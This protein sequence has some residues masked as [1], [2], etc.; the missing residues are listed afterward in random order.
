MRINNESKSKNAEF[1]SRYQKLNKEQKLAVDTTDGPVMVIA[2]PGSGKTELLSLRVANILKLGLATPSNILCLTF[3]ENGA[4]NMRERLSSLIKED[5]FRVNI[6]TFHAFCNYVIGRYPEYFYNATN[7]SQA[8]DI[9]RAEIITEIFKSLLHKHPLS[10]KHPELGFAYL[11]DVTDR[12]KHIKSGGYTPEEYKTIV[13]SIKEDYKDINEVFALWPVERLNVKKLEVFNNIISSLDKLKT[14]TS[15]FIS[16]ALKNAVEESFVIGKT[17]PIADFKKKYLAVDESTPILKESYNYDK[18]LAVAEIYELYENKMHELGLYDYDDTIIEVAHILRNK[19]VLRNELEEQ[20]QY[21]MIDEFQ[22]TNLAQM[23][24]VKAITSSPIHEGHPNVCVVGDDDQAI[25]KF[26]GAEV[27]HIME[28]RE[29]TYKDVQTIV[30]DKNYRSTKDV[31]SF[32]RQIITKGK[33]RLENRFEDIVKELKSENK[34]LPNGKIEIIKYN[35]K[36]E[37]YSDV[38]RKIKK[39]LDDG[40]DPKEIA[41]L[42]RNHKDLQAILPYLDKLS[43]PYEYIKKANVFDEEH[44]RQLIIVCEYVSSVLNYENNKD[45]LLPEILSYKFLNLSHKEIFNVAVNAK[46]K[47]ISWIEALKISEDEKLHK[48]YELLTDLSVEAK[49]LP[50]ENLIEKFIEKSNFK[51]FYFS[52]EKLKNTP[53]TYVYFLA[54]LKTFIDALREWKKGETITASDVTQFVKM[55]KDNNIP[56]ISES[57]FTRNKFSIQ[58]M[59]AHAAKGLEFE[60]VFII[61][62]HDKPWTRGNMVNKAPIPS[63]LSQLINPAGDEEDDFIRLFF[64]AITRAKHTLH[65]SGH[66]EMLRYLP[67][68]LIK[69][70]DAKSLEISEEDHESILGIGVNK[71]KE[72]E[73]AMLSKLVENY[74]MP[75][76]HLNNFLDIKNG[77]PIFFVEQNLLHFPQPMNASGAYGSAIHKAIEEMIVYPKYNAGEKPKLSH[78]LS[79]FDFI[80]SRSRLNISDY[81]FMKDRGEIVLKKYYDEKIKS[82]KDD[83][84][85]EVDMKSEGVII[86]SAHLTGKID[87]LR[88]VN[89]FYEVIDFKTGKSFS[90][91]EGKDD[92]TKIKLHKYRQQLI[93]YKLLLENSS[94]YNK[95]SVKNLSLQF[96]EE[97]DEGKIIELPLDIN[98]A[99][100]ERVKKLIEAVYKK[101]VNLDFPDVSNYD[102]S[103]KGII[104]FEDDLINEII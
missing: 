39:V 9:T 63:A 91:W 29:K 103:Y 7:F 43:I 104:A 98:E 92:D 4:I 3:T 86:N 32:A 71:I 81:K 1:E 51:E 8:N 2:G 41:I 44:I 60:E 62:A 59:T 33:I 61:N 97:N 53:A 36:V 101:I 54:S 22:D 68:D 57:L 100:I 46:T 34:N 13:T 102:K 21:I 73:W 88:V 27:S 16:L 35:S 93:I 99:E 18:I 5:A 95:F 48:I 38:S 31:V 28:F 64:V 25:Y 12:I 50:L 84:K 47:N 89:N 11:K 69:E 94:S 52:K 15:K 23:S 56:L 17:E 42:S 65:I 76:T 77:G 6:F 26:Q 82:F 49:S 74:K 85:I 70:V 83:D 87:F 80:L 96:V 37:E 67:Q 79:K 20:Y 78:I 45:Y 14:T 24:L 90:S 66:E 40:V 19:N 55:H 72:D 75:V 30:L 10:A 58:L